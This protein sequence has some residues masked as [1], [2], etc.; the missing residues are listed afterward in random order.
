MSKKDVNRHKFFL[1]GGEWENKDDYFFSVD[2][3]LQH[4]SAA[5]LIESPIPGINHLSS[6]IFVSSSNNGIILMV[7]PYDLINLWNPAIRELIKIPSSIPKMKKSDRKRFLAIYGLGYVSSIDDYKIVRVGEK[8]N[9][10]GHFETDLFSMRDNSWKLIG[11]FPSYNFFREGD[12][13]SIDGIIY[14][15]VMTDLSENVN[16]STILSF[17][18]EK[19]QFEEVLFP[20]RILRFQ[21]PIL[22]VLED[23]L[24][25][26]RMH[27]LASRDFEVWHMKKDGSMSTTWSK[28]LTIPSMY[29]GRCLRRMKL[30]KINEYI[31]FLRY[32]GDFKV[33]N[34]NGE[35]SK[36]VEVPEIDSL[37]YYINWIVPYVESLFSPKQRH[38]RHF[39]KMDVSISEKKRNVILK[40]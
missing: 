12:I 5:S 18:L 23:N 21:N 27:D 24:C 14:M 2:T 36:I 28:I 20:D 10:N 39:K 6:V 30:M 4:D 15:I 8:D 29:Y 35:R 32:K 3:P 1:T 9:S 17:C 26:T 16:E 37:F 22:H 34:T 13:V 40:E 19:E 31:I 38:I 7:F 11:K 25:L 33:Y